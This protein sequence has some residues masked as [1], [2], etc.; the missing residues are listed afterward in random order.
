MDLR[1]LLI[2]RSRR[3]RR[4]VGKLH[5]RQSLGELERRFER[6]RKP[7]AEV[8]PH[9]Q[10]IDH[11]IDVVL[12][13]LVQRRRLGNLVECAVDLHPLEA[14]LHVFGELLAV[15]ALAAAHDRRKQIKPRA[16]GQREHTIDHLRHGLTFDRKPGRRRIGNA[17]ARPEKPHVVVDLRDGAHGRARIAGRGLLLDGDRRGQAVDLIH[18]RLLHHFQELARIGGEGLHVATLAL[19]VDRVER[20]RG[21]ARAGEPGEHHQLIAR[22]LDVDVLEIVLA[23]AADG[24]HAGVGTAG[25]AMVEEVVH[26]VRRRRGFPS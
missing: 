12:E 22:D 7:R 26:L 10:T 25:A 16:L 3:S 8:R 18:V 17:H 2:G 24:D 5:H 11:H 21:L 15:F 14:A 1:G 20:K 13:L 9:H 19:G 6:V 23:R 4:R